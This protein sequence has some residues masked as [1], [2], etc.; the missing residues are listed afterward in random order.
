[1]VSEQ[2]RQLVTETLQQVTRAAEAGQGPNSG[3]DGS[4]KDE[5]GSGEASHGGGAQGKTSIL[6]IV[7][8]KRTGLTHCPT[9]FPSFPQNLCL[10]CTWCPPGSR[11]GPSRK[12]RWSPAPPSSTR[13]C[14]PGNPSQPLP[15]SKPCWSCSRRQ[16]SRYVTEESRSSARLRHLAVTP[17]NQ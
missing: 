4:S 13:R 5:T 11:I 15:P 17:A 16:V 6:F 8:T 14:V 12:S 10:W 1:M 9:W 2:T 7:E 3:P